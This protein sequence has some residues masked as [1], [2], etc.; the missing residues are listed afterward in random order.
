MRMVDVHTQNN[1]IRCTCYPVCLL[2]LDRFHRLRTVMIYAAP[3]CYRLRLFLGECNF[4]KLIFQNISSF[5]C[6]IVSLMCYLRNSNKC[7]RRYTKILFAILR[8]D[9]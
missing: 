6:N 3:V 8:Y 2:E 5:T 4:L 1:V 7:Y 9:K